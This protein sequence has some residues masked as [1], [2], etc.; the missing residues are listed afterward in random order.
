MRLVTGVATLALAFAATNAHA[1]SILIANSADGVGGGCEL[2]APPGTPFTFYIF[3]QLAG[4]A[5]NGISGAEFRI[6]GLP[7][8]DAWSF[9][10][11]PNPAAN[12]V[13]GSPTADGVDIAFPACQTGAFGLVLL[14][15]VTGVNQSDSQGYALHARARIP[16][17]NASFDCPLVTLCDAQ[18]TKVCVSSNA[19][20][21][22]AQTAIVTP[23]HTPEPADGVTG[24]ATNAALHWQYGTVVA[25]YYHSVATHALRFGTDSNPPVVW[26]GHG[27]TYDPGPLLAHTRY[28]WG[29]TLCYSGVCAASPVWSFDT[30]EIVAVRPAEWTGVKLRFR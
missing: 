3:A 30:G 6:D 11:V 4:V 9:Q 10:F 26:S 29:V 20:L 5:G 28:Y 15:T 2:A 18:F 19:L 7:E 16:P 22:N 21:L 17:S 25:C 27:A 12:L 8:D 14:G 13:L 23:P 24:V 1:Q